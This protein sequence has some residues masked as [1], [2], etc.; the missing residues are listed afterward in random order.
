M[1]VGLAGTLIW[2]RMAISSK[3]EETSFV[4]LS[5]GALFSATMITRFNGFRRLCVE[6][7]EN[8]VKQ[9]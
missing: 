9:T 3:K 4:L 5:A 2:T 7:A 1:A 8:K 6:R